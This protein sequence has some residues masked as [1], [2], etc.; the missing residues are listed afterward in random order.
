MNSFTFYLPILVSMITCSGL[1]ILAWIW[2]VKIKNGSVADIFWS[3]NFPVIAIILLLLAEGF[4]ARL[5]LICGM[6]VLWGARLGIHLSDRIFSHL[7][8]EKGHDV[9]FRKDWAT[10]QHWKFFW[11][12]QAKAI[13]NLLLAI[14]LFIISNNSDPNLNYFEYVGLAL[15]VISLAGETIAD[16]QLDQFTNDPANNGL[17]C[18]KGLWHYSQHPNYFFERM[19]WG[20]YF[21]FASGSPYGYLGVLSPAILLYLPF[22][23]SGIPSKEKQSIRSK[24]DAHENTRQ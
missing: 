7:H 10:D 12:F 4:P 11:Y 13:S 20:S 3:V 24:G 1:M 16:F 23:V 19:M 8:K 18:N 21:I 9:D 14:P 2:A 5:F 22:N 17:V 6:V 15:W